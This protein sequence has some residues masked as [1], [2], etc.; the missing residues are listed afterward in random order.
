MSFTD[1][2]QMIP[3]IS[4]YL[5]DGLRALGNNSRK[6]NAADTRLINGSIDLDTS[7][8]N[9]Y[10]QANRWDYIIGYNNKAWFLEIHPATGKEVGVV[11]KKLAWLKN[12]LNMH[13]GGLNNL[14]ASEPYHWVASDKMAIPTTSRHYRLAATNGIIPKK[15]LELR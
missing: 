5:S 4:D 6:I 7:L 9:S 1:T 3:E 13:A 12:W 2:V 11:L 14:K 8:R 15:R 10:P